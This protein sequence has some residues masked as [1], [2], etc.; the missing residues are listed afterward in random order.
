MQTSSTRYRDEYDTALVAQWDDL[1]GWSD[2]RAAEGSFL[3]DVL[4]ARRVRS[5]LDTATGTGFHAVLLSQAGFAVT[6]IDGAVEMVEQARR[7]VATLA[8]GAVP[9]ALG[10]WLDHGSLPAGPFDAVICMGN[11]IAHLFSPA[12]LERALSNFRRLLGDEGT[13][14]LDH[15]NYDALLAGRISAQDRTYCCTGLKASVDLAVVGRDVVDITYQTAGHPPA[16][17]RT[18]AWAT[19]DVGAAIRASGFGAPILYG[20]RGVGFDPHG[21]EFVIHVATAAKR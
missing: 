13:L 21:S 18:R 14:V 1:L 7:N 4:S 9:C 15:R 2:R 20:P 17:I 8:A 3:V 11:S 5:V 19:D 12:D 16:T 10:D 6:A